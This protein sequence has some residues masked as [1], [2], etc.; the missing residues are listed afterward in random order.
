MKNEF[1]I[2]TN[3]N[4]EQ[5]N[6]LEKFSTEKETVTMWSNPFYEVAFNF[7]EFQIFPNFNPEQQT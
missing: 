2:F 5:L 3:F 7:P 4:P 1:Q 6:T